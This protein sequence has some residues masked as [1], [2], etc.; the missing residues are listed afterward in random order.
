MGKGKESDLGLINETAAARLLGL[1]KRTL[2]N[3]RRDGA[4]PIRYYDIAGVIRYRQADVITFMEK[5]A[6]V[7]PA[8]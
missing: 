5:A 3:L 2:A 8:K 6:A 4:H 7:G 1:S